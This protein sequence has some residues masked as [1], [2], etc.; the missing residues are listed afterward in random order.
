M[1]RSTRP[2][3]GGSSSSPDQRLDTCCVWSDVER[4]VDDVGVEADLVGPLNGAGELGGADEADP[5]D[6]AMS[7]DAGARRAAAQ[8]LTRFA[9]RG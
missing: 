1:Q 9:G 2:A 8:V 3:R 5:L 7:I 6:W 4:G